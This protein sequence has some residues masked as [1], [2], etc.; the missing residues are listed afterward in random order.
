[1]KLMDRAR[2]AGKVLHLAEA[3]VDCYC[4]WIREFLAFSRVDGCWVEPAL[5]GAADVERFLTH[6]AVDRRVA[7]STQNQACNAIVFLY[8]KVLADELPPDHLGR[9]VAQRSRRP[10]RAA[11]VMSV[12]EVERVID[13]LA[14]GSVFRVIAR[15]LYGTGMRVAEC[16]TLRL[17]DLD[18]D[19]VQIIVRD[20]KGE[21]DR[22][23]MLPAS[24]RGE[25]VEQCR[26]VRTRHERDVLRGGGFV[27][28]PDVLANK[29][30]YA[31][32][33]W[34]W[35]FLFPSATRSVDE[36][37]NGHRWH[38][39]PGVVARAIRNAAR[40]SGVSKRVSPHTFRHSFATHLL[41][42][43]YDVRQV[44]TLLGHERLETTM[45]YTHVMNKPA[46][47]V[48]SP[49]DRLAAG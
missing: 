25:L 15:L 17:R 34:R 1:M 41:E 33:D 23:V 2:N 38:T 40:K 42:A 29:V 11:T 48:T 39:H 20:G 6:L 32:T 28:V 37:G 16:C 35:Q 22:I 24:L 31:Q 19:R 36:A 14:E 4:R 7:A 47:A 43:G 5:L 27:P 9:F 21:K 10:A 44:Q 8:R 26:K 30:P 49:L 3:T 46:V 12:G 13:A 18:F 45:R